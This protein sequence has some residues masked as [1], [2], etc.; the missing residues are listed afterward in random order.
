VS[1][2]F[3][4]ESQGRACRPY[5]AAKLLKLIGAL[6]QQAII[7]SSGGL[8]VHGLSY[9]FRSMPLRHLVEPRSTVPA[10]L[11]LLKIL[12]QSQPL[13][14]FIYDEDISVSIPTLNQQ[15]YVMRETV[16]H[17]RKPFHRSLIEVRNDMHFTTERREELG[18]PD[19]PVSIQ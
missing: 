2:T 19:V 13:R 6:A 7:L 1:Q 5:S 11:F 18:R 16:A 17:C 9:P 4:A 14:M 10:F 12:R 3:L 15:H 8:S